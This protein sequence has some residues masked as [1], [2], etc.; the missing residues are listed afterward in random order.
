MDTASSGSLFERP[1]KLDILETSPSLSRIERTRKAPS[2][3]HTN[4]TKWNN[5]A[6]IT[7]IAPSPPCPASV[8]SQ[9]HAPIA[10]NPASMYPA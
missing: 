3:K 8:G 9:F 5:I 1:L 2:L 4:T 6:V 10:V 7:I